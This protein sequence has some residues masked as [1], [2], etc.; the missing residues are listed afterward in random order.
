MLKI[1]LLYLYQFLRELHKNIEE[2]DKSIPSL[3]IVISEEKSE[4][5]NLKI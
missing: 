2:I 4:W 1:F 5:L 3:D